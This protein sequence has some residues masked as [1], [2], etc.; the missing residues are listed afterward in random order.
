MFSLRN[1]IF[2]NADYWWFKD[3]NIYGK[4]NVILII[5]VNIYD[6]CKM[7]RKIINY[8]DDL[9]KIFFITVIKLIPM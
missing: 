7:E 3:K 1:T 8:L 6:F 9:N 2:I 4:Y 5:V